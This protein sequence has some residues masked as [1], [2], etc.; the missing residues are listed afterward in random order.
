MML[1]KVMIVD[2][3]SL[4]HQMYRLVLHRYGCEI[5]DAMNGQEALDLLAGQ[6]GVELIIL[7]INMPVMNGIQFLEKASA[8]GLTARIPVIV[9]ST[10]GKEDDILRGLKLGAR[11]YLKKPFNPSVLHDLIEKIISG[12]ATYCTPPPLTRKF[13]A[14]GNRNTA[15][16]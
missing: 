4:I 1:N 10:E 11:G 12:P 7:D 9:V 3:S 5:I 14:D 2:D 16:F 15:V 13:V 8:L 6:P